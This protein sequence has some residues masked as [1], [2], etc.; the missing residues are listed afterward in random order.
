MLKVVTGKKAKTELKKPA[1]A[2]K[3]ATKKSAT[4]KPSPPKEQRTNVADN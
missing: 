4:K 2:K 1:P 3:S